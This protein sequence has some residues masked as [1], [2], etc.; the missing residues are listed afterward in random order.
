ME[1]WMFCEFM[2]VRYDKLQRWKTA[3]GAFNRFETIYSIAVAKLLWWSLAKLK[4]KE[5]PKSASVEIYQRIAAQAI[6]VEIVLWR[7]WLTFFSLSFSI[8]E[9]YRL[10]FNIFFV[11]INLG[12]LWKVIMH[13]LQSETYDNKK[14]KTAIADT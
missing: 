10:W 9:M 14:R 7:L 3:G 13:H 2:I 6:V 11:Q 1:K 12:S 5:I 8:K 4:L